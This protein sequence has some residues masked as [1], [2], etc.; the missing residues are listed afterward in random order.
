[1]VEIRTLFT[2]YSGL[3]NFTNKITDY[4]YFVSELYYEYNGTFLI[5]KTKQ[6]NMLTTNKKFLVG[7]I[8]HKRTKYYT[9]KCLI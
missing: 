8:I 9:Y 7:L 1:M 6:Y 4:L 5:T 2:L 3:K